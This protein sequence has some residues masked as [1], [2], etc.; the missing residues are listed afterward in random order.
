MAA[1]LLLPVLFLGPSW[2]SPAASNANRG[3]GGANQLRFVGH[4][5]PQKAKFKSPPKTH[6]KDQAVDD[7]RSRTRCEG[8]E[9]PS[10]QR[11]AGLGDG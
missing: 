4:R 6:D 2:L 9:N 5:L 3:L 11:F 7:G 8:V 10:G 1:S